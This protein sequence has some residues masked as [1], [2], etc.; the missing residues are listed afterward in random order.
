M[1]NCWGCAPW[2]WELLGLRGLVGLRGLLGARK[3]LPQRLAEG[4]LGFQ[5]STLDQRLLPA[6]I[7]RRTMLPPT[8]PHTRDGTS[9]P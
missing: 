6:A 9:P 7:M 2:C 4:G 8:A 5:R 1:D 3:G